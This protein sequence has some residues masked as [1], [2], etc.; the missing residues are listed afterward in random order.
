[1]IHLF[2]FTSEEIVSL[3]LLTGVGQAVTSP[4]GALA[5]LDRAILGHPS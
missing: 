4:V 1:M 2:Y 3:D 5:E